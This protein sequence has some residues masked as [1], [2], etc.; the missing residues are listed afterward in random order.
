MKNRTIIAAFVAVRNDM[1]ERL[2]MEC[3][4]AHTALIDNTDYLTT[5]W[6]WA[7]MQ[8]RVDGAIDALREYY[9]AGGKAAGWEDAVADRIGTHPSFI[10]D[11]LTEIPNMRFARYDSDVVRDWIEH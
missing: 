10:V 7:D 4:W 3:H 8:A 5:P 11:E 9:E 2:V 1:L 6:E